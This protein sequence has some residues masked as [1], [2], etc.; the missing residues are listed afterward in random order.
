MSLLSSDVRSAGMRCQGPALLMRLD[1]GAFQ[2]L[3]QQHPTLRASMLAVAAER[4]AFSTSREQ[5]RRLTS[6][7]GGGGASPPSPPEAV[8]AAARAAAGRA[9]AMSAE[10]ARV[11]VAQAEQLEVS[12]Q[13]SR[14]PPRL[15]SASA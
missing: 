15:A 13:S 9:P 6:G 11:V 8:V 4:A 3:T 5:R 14:P 1:I 12:K 7:G 2:Q 10:D